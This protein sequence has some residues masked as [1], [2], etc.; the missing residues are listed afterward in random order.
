MDQIFDPIRK[1]YVA[2]TPEEQVR[3]HVIRVLTR[4]YGYPE[5]HLAVEYAFKYN[6]LQY[7][8]DIVV[9]NRNLK[10]AMLVECKAADVK[11]TEAVIDQVVRYNRVLDVP[12]IFITNGEVSYLCHRDTQGD[13][14]QQSSMPSFDKLCQE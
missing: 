11:L 12:W 14:L 6:K 9:F 5:T 8:S 1:K 7:R 2:L 13:Y 3:Q 10:P 4:C